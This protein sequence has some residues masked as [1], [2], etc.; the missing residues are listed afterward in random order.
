MESI[1]QSHWPDSFGYSVHEGFCATGG[2]GKSV[3]R[4]A[5]HFWS[6]EVWSSPLLLE[7][8]G[9]RCTR[10]LAVYFIALKMD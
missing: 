10:L 8:A 7:I 4:K 6:K 3:S 2:G 9:M 1:G 5:A